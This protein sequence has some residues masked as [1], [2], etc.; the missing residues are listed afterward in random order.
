M[1]VAISLLTLLLTGCSGGV[2]TDRTPA[3]APFGVMQLWGH[4]RQCQ[5]ASDRTELLRL[6]GQFE[7]PMPS[8]PEPPAWIAQWGA[9]VAK[10]P[11]R[12]AVDPQALGAACTLRAAEVLAETDHVAEAR[13]LYQVVLIRYSSREWAYYTQLAREALVRL[14]EADPAVVA[15]RPAGS[16]SR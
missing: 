10:Q 1:R 13:S 7:R 3:D 15:R 6:V 8:G 11:L 9:Y 14:K 16:P 4:Y 12:L 2:F 5:T